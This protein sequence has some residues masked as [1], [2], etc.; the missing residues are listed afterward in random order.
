LLAPAGQGEPH[1]IQRFREDL[2]RRDN[3]KTANRRRRELGIRY[4]V[5][6]FWGQRMDTGPASSG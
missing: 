6:V 1:A 5:D 3:S 2:E 4:T